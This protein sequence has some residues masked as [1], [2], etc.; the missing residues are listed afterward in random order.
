MTNL[1]IK[2]TIDT[3]YIVS[4]STLF[5]LIGGLPI[6][7]LLTVWKNDGIAP[8]VYGEK[9]LSGIVNTVR[10]IPFVI[11]IIAL[12]PFTRLIVG[13]SYGVEASIVALVVGA[14]PFVARLVESALAEVDEGLIKAAITMGATPWQIVDN[15]YLVESVPALIRLVSLTMITLVGYAAMAGV[16]GGGGL[17]DI[18]IRYGL[19]RY[20]TDVML[21]TIVIMVIMVQLIQSGF[22][23]IANRLD[24][25]RA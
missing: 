11:L 25:R 20:Q 10:S 23:F 16:V 17:G 2:G 21:L 14:I 15:V 9:L 18:A 22:N 4:M 3:L 8:F 1:L 12:F 6:G 5:A 24:R 13:R 7:V 19:H